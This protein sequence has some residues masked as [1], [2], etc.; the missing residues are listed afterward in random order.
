[1]TLPHAVSFDAIVKHTDTPVV[2]DQRFLE[3]HEIF[4]EKN[5]DLYQKKDDVFAALNQD[6]KQIF[7]DASLDDDEDTITFS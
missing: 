6:T 2:S 7:A 3:L 1:V 5:R 4:Y